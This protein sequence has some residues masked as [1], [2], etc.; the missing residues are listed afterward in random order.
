MRSGGS[1]KGRVGGVL[2]WGGGAPWGKEEP[3]VP[4]RKKKVFLCLGGEAPPPHIFERRKEAPY[5]LEEERGAA[6][7][8]PSLT[9]PPFFLQ[10]MSILR[11]PPA[12]P[13]SS[14]A[15]RSSTR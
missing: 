12:T 3:L 7:G 6:V 11:T 15:L 13:T 10:I 9:A 4:M 2:F 5:L 1:L 14:A 8:E